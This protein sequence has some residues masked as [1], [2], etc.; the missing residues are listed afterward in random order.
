M[1]WTAHARA[2]DRMPFPKAFSCKPV[3]PVELVVAISSL[4][5]GMK[6]EVALNVNSR[7]RKIGST[8]S[9]TADAN[10][11]ESLAPKQSE[12]S[13]VSQQRRPFIGIDEAAINH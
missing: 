8:Q 2:A 4:T 11:E 6:L 7:R 13:K 9:P 10:S 3:E 5:S 1:R 12:L